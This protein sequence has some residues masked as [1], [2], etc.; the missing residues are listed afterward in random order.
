[1]FDAPPIQT[2]VAPFKWNDFESNFLKETFTKRKKLFSCPNCNRPGSGSNAGKQ[3]DPSQG[4]ITLSSVECVKTNGGCGRK[5][6]VSSWLKASENCEALL[7]TFT[8]SLQLAQQAALKRAAKGKSV[9]TTSKPA[10]LKQSRLAFSDAVP[11][12]KRPRVSFEQDLLPAD[13][14]QPSV[15][16]QSLLPSNSLPS[17]N[18]T[19]T[20]STAPPAST[21]STFAPFIAPQGQLAAIMARLAKIEGENQ[22]FKSQMLALQAENAS[23]KAQLGLAPSTAAALTLD[24]VFPPLT[25]SSRPAPSHPSA[26]RPQPLSSNINHLAQPPLGAGQPLFPPRGSGQQ[27]FAAVAAAPAKPASFYKKAA[28]RLLAPRKDP[29]K[30]DRLHVRMNDSR[31][32]K[33]CDTAKQVNK[34]ISDC[35]K[36]YGIKREVIRFSKIGNSVLELYFAADSRSKVID[37]L[38]Y[39]QCEILDD[40]DPLARPTYGVDNTFEDKAVKRLAFLY[41]SANLVNLRATILHGYPEV[42]QAKVVGFA[43]ELLE[44]PNARY[45]PAP[46]PRNQEDPTK[47]DIDMAEVI[48]DSQATANPGSQPAGHS[49]ITAPL[50][51]QLDG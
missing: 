20:A 2:I 49:T 3:G 19:F 39:H 33:R 42:F 48:P 16:S 6:R 43:T 37:N 23:L 26:R 38:V 45:N 9:A 29:A 46:A 7:K 14:S 4:G 10:P 21:D 27:S 34:L 17:A 41:K 1:M 44:D 36:R 47:E 50:Q 13:T 11:A 8:D 30:F 22:A 15:N 31:S 12:T 25:S 18:F 40:F 28:S 24:S 32:L 5:A 35:L 51:A